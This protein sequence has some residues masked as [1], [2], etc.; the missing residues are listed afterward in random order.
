MRCRGYKAPASQDHAVNACTWTQEPSSPSRKRSG[1]SSSSRRWT[2]RRASLPERR[3]V[4]ADTA[5][6]S[7]FCLA[8]GHVRLASCRR[9]HQPPRIATEGWQV[10]ATLVKCRKQLRPASPSPLRPWEASRLIFH[11]GVT[12]R[13]PEASL[14]YKREPR[15]GFGFVVQSGGFLWKDSE[16]PGVINPGFKPAPRIR[17]PRQ[18]H[19]RLLGWKICR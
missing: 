17:G 4:R 7:R 8:P 11:R 14:G 5:L 10:S 2:A 18:T 15:P 13:L 19:L 9:I 3:R 12:G 1:Y 6:K 16:K